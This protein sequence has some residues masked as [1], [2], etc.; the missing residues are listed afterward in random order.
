[1]SLPP[2]YDTFLIRE[3]LRDDPFAVTH[4]PSDIPTLIEVYSKSIS[5]FTDRNRERAVE[6]LQYEL[7][8]LYI[9]EQKW[10]NALPFLLAVY[11][12]SSWRRDGW[13]NLLALLREQVSDVARACG[14]A[15]LVLRAE[16]EG[17]CD[18]FPTKLQVDYDFSGCL[19]GLEKS[20]SSKPRAVVKAEE[21]VSCLST[22]FGFGSSQGNVGEL[23]PA[24]LVITS[25][26][27]ASTSPLTLSQILI[28][29]NSSLEDVKIEH[30]AKED[31][32]SSI[33]AGPD[34]Y[35]VILTTGTTTSDPSS[36]TASY[37][38]CLIGTCDLTFSPGTAKAI[39]F[40]LVAKDAGVIR[41]ASITCTVETDSFSLE[42]VVSEAE[43][44]HQAD[45]WLASVGR[46]SR[47]DAGNKGL[48]EIRIHPKPPK[49]QIGLPTL[50]KDYLTD[51]SVR[52][53]VE[54]TNE[55]D[56]DVEV[57]IEARFL[58]QADLVPVWTWITDEAPSSPSEDPLNDKQGRPSS[59][60]V[61]GRIVQSASHKAKATFTA[62]SLPTEAVLE[63]KALYHVVGEP[64]TPI[65]K[66]LI[67][68][69]IFDRPF[70]ANLDFQP[71]VDPKPWPS[72]FYPDDLNDD[73]G[74]AQGLRQIWHS[75]TRVA[76]FATESLIVEDLAL[77]LV[78]IHEGAICHISSDSPAPTSSAIT[79]APKDSHETRF[80]IT[81]QKLD[82]DDRRST[83]LR[84]QLQIR[85]RR[86]HA[87]APSTTT[88]LPVPDLLIPFG[89]PRVLAS[90]GSP[91]R[92]NDDDDNDNNT[93]IIPLTYTLENPSTHVLN[94]ALSME[95]SD[96]FAFSGPKTTTVNLVPVA[97]K[98]ITYNMI[99][100]VRGGRW[101][102]PRLRVLDTGFRQ[103]VR[104]VGT[105]GMR[106]EKVG[107][108]VWVG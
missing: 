21:S 86:N 66:V 3:P 93:S 14:D 10:S 34:V 1:M 39:S 73:D 18:C 45:F 58:G 76:S 29:F 69:V 24:Q 103:V 97:R 94:F 61:L 4:N 28:S 47:R 68:E 12:G 72:Y 43:S 84:F 37:S 53:D 42:H 70:E 25:H 98:T 95:T 23:L 57:T 104:V 54:I 20:S 59:E 38:K 83:T 50:R 64:H 26:A 65:S 78:D 31:S 82:L 16:W 102:T 44:M 2:L 48:N 11:Q 52:M 6:R 33:S 92:A 56:D 46:P 35:D 106:S 62:R 100:L 8:L 81:A 77:R 17:L 19:D 67:Q 101:V 63:I 90:A 55:E 27:Q 80:Q 22:T 71:C 15:E 5:Y 75:N 9:R 41:V 91:R 32:P 60:L 7:A 36:P 88:T 87:D 40:N 108:G 30:Q 49:V 105:G 107:V 89:E 99:P 85:W 79:L 13:W 51:E 74:S 96:D